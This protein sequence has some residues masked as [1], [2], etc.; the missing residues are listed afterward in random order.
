MADSVVVAGEVNEPQVGT[1]DGND[2]GNIS[3]STVPDPI[4]LKTLKI[5]VGVVKRLIKDKASYEKEAVQ[6]KEKLELYKKEGKEEHFLRNA[7]R[8]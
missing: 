8:H 4:V 2:E 1:A 7:V 5:K 3:P 6:Q